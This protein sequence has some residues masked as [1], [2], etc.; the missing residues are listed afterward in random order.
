MVDKKVV[1]EDKRISE[2][3]IVEQA[4]TQYTPVVYD[5]E[6][7]AAYDVYAALAKLMNDVEN[8]KKHIHG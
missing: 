4:P 5:Q 6:T 2:R 1:E 8:I 3:Y 7:K